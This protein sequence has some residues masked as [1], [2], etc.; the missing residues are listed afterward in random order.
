MRKR[1]GF[2]LVELIVVLAVIGVLLALLLPAIQQAREAA[3]RAVCRNNLK[4]IGLAIHN[5]HDIHNCIPLA[6]IHTQS[7]PMPG[8]S[9]YW[10]W[11]VALLP[12]LEQQPLYFKLNPHGE[13]RVISRYYQQYGVI[14][15]GGET[16]LALFRCPS[17]IL[18]ARATDVGPGTLS[19]HV[20]GY[21]ATD[22]K[23][24][25]GGMFTNG[26]FVWD[27]PPVRFAD[28]T[29]GT[30]STIAVGEAS[31][32]GRSGQVF[33]I[34]LGFFNYAYENYFETR[35]PINCV[36]SFSGRFWMNAQGDGCALSMHPGIA[37]FLFADG[38][39]RV[40][41]QS[42]DSTVYSR[43]GDRNDGRVVSLDF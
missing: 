39:V 27:K 5:Y 24:S 31:Y 36:P 1:K 16:Q 6:S 28:A 14:I 17:S 21:A 11:E 43:L 34:W 30:S 26:M 10:G 29:D 35:F 22:Y 32:P 18:P 41:S 3:R 15:P 40:L 33:P 20:R 19:R 12:Y 4:Q 8:V 7:T 42:I 9:G 38:S 13:P 37:Q 25:N 2:T 23:G